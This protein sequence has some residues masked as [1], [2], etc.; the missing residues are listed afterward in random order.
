MRILHIDDDAL[1]R[2]IVSSRLERAGHEIFG[3]EDGVAGIARYRELR[4]ELDLILTD[5]D[6]PRM[7]GYETA[8]LLRRLNY[9]GPLIALSGRTGAV[10]IAN[11]RNAG[12]DDCMTKPLQDDFEEELAARVARLPSRPTLSR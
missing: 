4:P 9:T 7:D 5:I 1:F 10:D 3:A 2:K 11:A 8:A 12:C 6:M